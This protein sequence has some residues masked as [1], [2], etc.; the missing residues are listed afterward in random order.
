M[1][2]LLVLITVGKPEEAEEIARALVEE[3]LAAC[4]NILPRMKSVYWWEG[5][6]EQAEETLLLV[7]TME[8]RLHELIRRVKQIH[9]YEVP[10]IIALGIVEGSLDYLNWIQQALERS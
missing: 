2:Y 5:A 6:V 9:S 7:K 8:G 3:H 1:K 4:V 10:E